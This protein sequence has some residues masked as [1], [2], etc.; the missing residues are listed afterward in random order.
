MYKLLEK[1]EKY[2]DIVVWGFGGRGKYLF[3]LLQNNFPN[4]SLHLCDRAKHT[5]HN[6]TILL[7]EN[8]YEQY[9]NALFVVGI[10]IQKRSIIDDMRKLGIP[11]GNIFLLRGV[12]HNLDY[13][14]TEHCNLNCIGCCHFSNLAKEEFADL[15]TFEKDTRQIAKIFNQNLYSYNLLGGEPL[16]H[17]DIEKFAI[18]ART[19]LPKSIIRIL[20]NGILLPNMPDSFWVTCNS[21]NIDINVTHLPIKINLPLIE[22]KRKEFGVVVIYTNEER[23]WSKKIL[24]IEGT[25][26]PEESFRNCGQDTNCSR[27]YKGRLYPCTIVGNA[28]HFNRKFGSNLAHA[29][30]DSLDIYAVNN[31]QEIFDWISKPKHFCRYCDVKKWHGIEWR[32]STKTIEEY[33]LNSP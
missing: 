8:A 14:L 9:Q 30:E 33:L 21:N 10:E 25:C 31:A 2:D 19:I 28:E 1:A 32:T 6:Y 17:P 22:K 4:K 15:E 11:A 3:N 16:L 5:N 29:S 20:T 12:T 13:H 24:N 26:D 18:A 23:A 27:L 7:P